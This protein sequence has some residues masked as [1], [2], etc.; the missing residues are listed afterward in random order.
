MTRN[1]AAEDHNAETVVEV[2]LDTVVE[3]AIAEF[4]QVA[5]ITVDHLTT[6]EQ[7][8]TILVWVYTSEADGFEDYLQLFS[9]D[10]RIAISRNEET[11][12][13]QFSVMATFDGPVTWDSDSK[14]TIYM[15][16]GVMGAEPVE[17]EDGL[18]YLQDKLEN[19]E[20]WELDRGRELQLE[21][22]RNYTD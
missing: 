15:D 17:L 19:P 18:A 5:S 8:R 9:S 2:G 11:I 14:T 1:D 16:Q 22:I 20:Q 13:A 21:Q 4:D 6:Y 3:Q 7:P 12:L 10:H